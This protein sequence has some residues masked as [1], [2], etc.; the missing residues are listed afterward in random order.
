MPLEKNKIV[1]TCS[2]RLN[3]ALEKELTLLGYPV[4]HSSEKAVITQ[5]DF[6]DAMRLNYCLRTGNRVL[7]FIAG[8]KAFHP[9]KLYQQVKQIEW[10]KYFGDNAY[11]SIDSSVNN[12][13]IKDNR[14]ANLRVKDA[15][16]D[17]FNKVTG[18]RPDSGPEKHG[19]VIF[20]QW[21][22]DQA[23][24]YFDTSGDTIAKHNYR[25]KSWKAPM[26]ENLA[27]GL[28]LSTKWNKN[29]H[30]IDPMC[31][32]GTLALEACMMA[33][34]MFPGQLR[35]HYAF[36]NL[37]LFNQAEWVD[38]KIK[39][40][41]KIPE[42]LPLSIIASDI[43]RNAVN[44][45]RDNARKAGIDH[46]IQFKVSDFQ[47]TDVPE[48]NGV[49]M[50][51][52]EYGERMGDVE[53]LTGLY[54]KMGDFFKHQCVGYAAYIFTGNMELAKKIGLKAN[55]RIPFYNGKI[56]CRLLE[57]EIYQGSKR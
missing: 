20:L 37:S 26:L 40:N 48:G 50:M 28:I 44:A 14:F 43:D 24:I 38:V 27:A 49:V 19:V 32:S 41:V 5:G 11:L 30:F 31:G 3:I 13:F 54:S 46:L 21:N 52:P 36:Q 35:N 55:R 51:N 39:N 15:I 57:Y 8:F 4:V 22:D 18:R 9:D 29:G 45:A 56:D 1:V 34:G 6:K 12:K 42:E 33:I 2:P 47:F 10:E 16:V 7:W 17:R 25:I 53:K 23:E